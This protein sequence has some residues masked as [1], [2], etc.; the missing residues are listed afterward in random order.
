MCVCV[1]VCVRAFVRVC[2]QKSIY[3]TKSKLTKL[4]VLALFHFFTHS[5]TVTHTL[6][7]SL[8]HTLSLCHSLSLPHTHSIIKAINT[9]KF[10]PNA[11]KN[12]KIERKSARAIFGDEGV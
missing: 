11:K 5:H 3:I 10:D 4:S 12:V 7:L 6:S 9:R 8:T 1:C 2:G